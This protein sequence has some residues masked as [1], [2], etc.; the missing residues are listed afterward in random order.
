[1]L[2]GEEERLGE[3]M[4][5]EDKGQSRE[6][7]QFQEE[8]QAQEERQNEE[9]RQ[10]HEG[11]H[12]QEGGSSQEGRQSQE[13]RETQEEGEVVDEGWWSPDE[14]FR[15][16]T[17]NTK[18]NQ[19][20]DKFHHQRCSAFSTRQNSDSSVMLV[21]DHLASLSIS[22]TFTVLSNRHL[23]PRN[24]PLSSATSGKVSF[25]ARPA[26]TRLS[27]GANLSSALAPSVCKRVAVR[28]VE[29]ELTWMALITSLV[30]FAI[31][32]LT[33]VGLFVDR[34]AALRSGQGWPLWNGLLRYILG[35]GYRTAYI[36]PWIWFCRHA[37]LQQ[38]A[39][40]KIRCCLGKAFKAVG[41]CWPSVVTALVERCLDTGGQDC[42]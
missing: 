34:L 8:R 36:F 25:Q 35:L 26:T 42:E 41:C 13:G 21:A 7:R 38:Y 10:S 22:S 1:M 3:D 33:V 39:A 23:P 18:M 29:N 14:N 4:P 24:H 15:Q 16:L 31:F 6:G 27:L 20:H 17:G 12:S 9:E 19:D 32:V 5:L 2:Y 28:H 11:R 40:R 37:Q 30:L